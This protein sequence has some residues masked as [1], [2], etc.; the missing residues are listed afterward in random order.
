MATLLHAASPTSPLAER[1]WD[2]LSEARASGWVWID[3]NLN[4][5]I[6]Q[7][8]QI[9]SLSESDVEDI[10]TQTELPKLEA[11][12]DYL[13]MVAHTPSAEGTRFTTAEIDLILG[14]D[15]LITIHRGAP[16]GI[17]ALHET[18][19]GEIVTS[20]SELFAQLVKIFAARFLALA[21][22]LDMSIDELEESAISGDPRSLEKLQAL[23]RDAIRLR[24][25][26]FPLREASRNLEMVQASLITPDASRVIQAATDDIST[27][28]EAVDTGRLL[29][30]AVLDTYRASVSERMNEVMKVLTV[31]SAI[32][33]PL[34]LLAGIYGMN[35]SNMPELAIPWAYFGLLG[36]MAALGL[37]LWIYFARRGFIGGPRVPRVDRV[38]GRGLSAFVH[39][40]LAPTRVLRLPVRSTD[41]P[42]H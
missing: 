3:L 8:A 42:P 41:E 5:G 6:D 40:T 28:L 9:V 16:P 18:V 11:R 23:R 39:L 30:A 12:P 34:G 17:E 20:P 33:L 35:F 31:F 1:A 32:V 7:L 2:E 27:S 4:E 19:I 14:A 21:P 24:R 25:V 29:M 37:G 13:F 26:L 15:F 22:A 38:V 10:H 36:V